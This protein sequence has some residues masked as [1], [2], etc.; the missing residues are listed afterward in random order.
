MKRDQLTEI[1]GLDLKTLRSRAVS[2]QGEI[3]DLVIDKHMKKM[4]DLK[5]ISKKRK[6][7]AQILTVVTQK[8]LLEQLEKEMPV[9]EKKVSAG[10]SGRKT[11][12]KEENK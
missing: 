6:D 1:K 5:M 11:K 3:A 8:G 10:Q 9:E 7:L 2:L 4:K 12:Q